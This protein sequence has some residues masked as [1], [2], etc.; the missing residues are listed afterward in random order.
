MPEKKLAQITSIDEYIAQAP[1]QG[2]PFLKKIRSLAKRLCPHADEVI[3][4]GMPALKEGRVFFYF[5][6]FKSHIGIYPP[7]PDD[8]PLIKELKEFRGPKGNLQFQY[9]GDIPYAL[10]EKVVMELHHRH[11]IRK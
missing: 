10:I 9:L 2:Q 4:Y 5:A 8:S 11:A 3:S 6:A 7:I 1:E